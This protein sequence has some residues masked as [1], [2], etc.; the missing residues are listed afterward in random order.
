MILSYTFILLFTEGKKQVFEDNEKGDICC[1]PEEANHSS[2]RDGGAPQCRVEEERVS[3]ARSKNAFT[4]M[5]ASE[6]ADRHR[7]DL[8]QSYQEKKQTAAD[9]LFFSLCQIANSDCGESEITIVKEL[10][11]KD[12]TAGVTQ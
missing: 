4:S 5:S 9:A 3:M 7:S 10:N 12:W 2:G 11:L 6:P 8:L 1:S